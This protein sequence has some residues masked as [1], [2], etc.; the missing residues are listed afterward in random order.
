MSNTE[1][2]EKH[3]NDGFYDSGVACYVCEL[4]QQLAD[5]KCDMVKR[6]RYHKEQMAELRGEQ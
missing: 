6:E 3:S 4:E 5:L 1:V 2:C